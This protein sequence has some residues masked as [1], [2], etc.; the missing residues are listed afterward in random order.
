[1]ITSQQ[2][3]AKWIYWVKCLTG[4]EEYYVSKSFNRSLAAGA[5]I[6]NANP[7]IDPDRFCRVQV[8]HAIDNRQRIYPT[9]LA[10]RSLARYKKYPSE[11]Q[12][13]RG[14]RASLLY[15]IRDFAAM[16]QVHGFDR[17]IGQQLPEH[18]P[19]FIGLMYLDYKQKIP[20]DVLVNARSQFRSE[21]AYRQVLPAEYVALL[22]G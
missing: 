9:L 17:A 16:V 10:G 1:M 22:E 18:T 7:G 15:E 21:P 14:F 19:V 5:K 4:V 13:L 8:L 6:L 3:K 20:D 2:L 12:E 11:I